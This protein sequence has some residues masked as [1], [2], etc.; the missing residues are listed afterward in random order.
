M[1]VLLT[2]LEA[3]GCNVTSEQRKK[4]RSRYPL[5]WDKG[6]GPNFRC[7]SMALPARKTPEGRGR[8]CCSSH[9]ER[10]WWWHKQAQLCGVDLG[11]KKQEKKEEKKNFYSW[12]NYSKISQL[13]ETS[14][15]KTSVHP[16]LR[17]NISTL[18]VQTATYIKKLCKFV[19]RQPVFYSFTENITPNKHQIKSTPL[20]CWLLSDLVKQA[21]VISIDTLIWKMIYKQTD[22]KAHFLPT[23]WP[24][25]VP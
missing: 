5:S 19:M 20:Q 8:L 7:W 12:I 9:S 11:Q 23:F 18:T 14:L 4:A 10:G 25:C 22:L 1:P 21:E 13:L 17:L 3:R 16:L 6:V 15:W 2:A 24:F